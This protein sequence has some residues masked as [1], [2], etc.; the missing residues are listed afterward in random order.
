MNLVAWL[1]DA[2]RDHDP[3]VIW[4]GG[5]C[6][7]GELRA[8]VRGVAALVSEIVGDAHGAIVPIVGAPSVEWIASYLGVLHAGAV[9]ALVP[10]TT[11]ANLREVFGEVGARLAFVE[12]AG[13]ND[14]AMT[15]RALGEG[16][17]AQPEP[18][19]RP[20]SALTALLYTSGSTGRPKGVMLSAANLVVNADAILAACPLERSDRAFVTLPFFY[21]YGLSVLHTFLRVGASIYLC[22][23][24]LPEVM[25]DELVESDATGMPTVPSLLQTLVT[26]STLGERRPPKLRY[27]MVSGGRLP[28][29]AIDKFAAVLPAATLHVRYGVT[30]L[31]AA[32]SFLAPDLL[33]TKR[34]SIG[35]GSACGA[36]AVERPD[37][38]P[39]ARDT[40]EVGELVVRGP[41]VAQ[42]YFRDEVLS[43]ERF[44]D[45]A[46]F[47][48]DL[49][50]VD[51]DGF[52]YLVGRRAELIKTIGHRVA[53]AE[54]EGVL[55]SAPGVV[56]AGVCG[57]PH[58]L[59]GEAIA[60]AVVLAP[61]AAVTSAS[62]IEHCASE[63][64][65]FKVPLKIV[66]VLELPKTP[67]RK[68]DRA[69]LAAL[70][71]GA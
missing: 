71:T 60:A 12:D 4:R 3:A 43:R 32:A 35:R 13:P 50:R 70:L 14:V 47:T 65:A 10:P 68:L 56:E 29:A 19:H 7:Y 40:G 8:R 11:R 28:D 39:V 31:S 16:A 61:G 54:I 2:G 45:G 33:G 59:R 23:A 27:V 48:G 36:L 30:E 69:R 21:C 15:F 52:V 67:S 53:P 62:L 26:R 25:V 24:A 37:G 51:G 34:G 66:I 5:R 9:P 6:S 22:R 58:P 38:E 1:L 64:P 42:G 18:V 49:A 57:L 63:L 17:A 41:H 20:A 55:A 46:F 44:R